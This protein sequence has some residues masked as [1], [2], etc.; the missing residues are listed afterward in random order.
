MTVAGDESKEHLDL[1]LAIVFDNLPLLTAK[2][3][4]RT[5]GLVA[6]ISP[7]G[8]PTLVQDDSFAYR[9]VRPTDGPDR[10]ELGAIGHGPCAHEIAKRMVEQIQ[11]WNCER[12]SHRAH[13]EVHPAGTPDDRLP[14]GRVIDRPHT[15][16]AITWP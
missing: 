10:F 15:R 14:A 2:P 9:T 5:R 12:R 3:A 16:I 1:W 13:I 7:L 4:A 11:D 8:I 6:S